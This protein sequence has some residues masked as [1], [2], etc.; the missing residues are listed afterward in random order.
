MGLISGAR[1]DTLGAKCNKTASHV[2]ARLIRGRARVT[3]FCVPTHTNITRDATK[4]S[5]GLRMIGGVVGGGAHHISAYAASLHAHTH[6][7]TQR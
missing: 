2:L 4:I 6:T 7:H 5:I 1:L 3:K